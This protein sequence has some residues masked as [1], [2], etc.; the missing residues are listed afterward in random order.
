MGAFWSYVLI[1]EHE[2]L[3][4]GSLPHAVRWQFS[5]AEGPMAS[6][7]RLSLGQC[8][9]ETRTT[10][11]MVSHEGEPMGSKSGCINLSTVKADV[12]FVK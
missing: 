5:A 6:L 12:G 1:A 8:T 11:A 2:V 7:H 9:P 4:V 3:C 10:A